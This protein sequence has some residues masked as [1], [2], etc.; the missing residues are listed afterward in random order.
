MKVSALALLATLCCAVPVMAQVPAPTSPATPST[1]PAASV[2]A[3]TMGTDGK[4]VAKEVREQCRATAKAQGLQ[5]EQREAAVSECFIKQ[6]PDLAA[7][8]TARMQCAGDAKAKGLKPGE[9][10]KAFMKDC[11]KGKV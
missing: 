8:E 9:E 2:P 7:K 4:P 3:P 11:I 5:G 1:T 10:R 6:R